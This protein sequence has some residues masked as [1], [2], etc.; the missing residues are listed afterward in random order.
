MNCKLYADIDKQEQPEIEDRR[1]GG[2]LT[3]LLQ[4]ADGEDESQ[5]IEADLDSEE[6]VIES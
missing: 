2:L 3:S 4:F 5:A 1:F 6:D